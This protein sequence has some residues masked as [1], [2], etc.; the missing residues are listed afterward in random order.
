MPFGIK[1]APAIF[2]IIVVV[3]F[4]YYIHKFLEFYFDDSTVFGLIKDHIESLRMMP[5]V[6]NCP[7]FEKVYFLCAFWSS[8]RPCGMS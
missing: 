6:P 3:V 2:S 4:K 8:F 1:N 7:Q 5:P